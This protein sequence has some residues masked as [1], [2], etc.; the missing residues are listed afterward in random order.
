MPTP[1]K[2]GTDY[3]LP[4]GRFVRIVG[5][6]NDIVHC[7]YLADRGDPFARPSDEGGVH[8]MQETFRAI[9]KPIGAPHA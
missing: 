6:Q 2:P 7:A 4:S 1:I 5:T 3:A 8:F 9:A